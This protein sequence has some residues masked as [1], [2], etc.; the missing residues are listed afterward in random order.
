MNIYT[1]QQNT[2]E[3]RN[4]PTHT[5]SIDFQQRYRGERT[6]VFST[7]GARI[8]VHAYAK[9]KQNPQPISHTI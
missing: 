6:F 7:N 3:S 5:Q 2:T 8:I 1:N 9:A 4:K